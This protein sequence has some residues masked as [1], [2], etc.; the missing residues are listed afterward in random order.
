MLTLNDVIEY[1]KD[2]GWQD[3]ITIQVT[4]GIG[5][6]YILTDGKCSYNPSNLDELWY[7]TMKLVERNNRIEPRTRYSK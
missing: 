4:E 5:N 2:E 6:G 7:A 3:E 1:I